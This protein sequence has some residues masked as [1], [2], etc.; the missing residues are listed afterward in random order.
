MARYAVRYLAAATAGSSPGGARQLR[1]TVVEA[2]DAQ[3]VAR[4]LAV[5]PADI[6]KLQPLDAAPAAA[7]VRSSRKVAFPLRL[8]SQELA[9]LLDAGI[10]LF[11][12]LVTLR[13]KE[14]AGPTVE[15]LTRVI[16][17]LEQGQ[18]FAQ[19]LRGCPEAFSSL[20]IA[21]IEASQR[22]GQI[23]QALRRH[24]EYLAWLAALR[25]KLV[26]AL[27]YPAILIAAGSLVMLFL[28]VF[29]VPR[30]AQIYDDL[31]GDLP[32]MSRVMLGFGTF[33]GQNP[34]IVAG[35]VAG[36]IAGVV[37]A[38]RSPRVR[39]MLAAQLWAMPYVGERMRLVELSALY[40]TLGLLLQAG[41]TAVPAMQASSELVS[42]SLRV[43]L[44]DATRRVRE[45]ARLSDSL[46]QAGL[47]TPVSLRMMRV[48]EHS[49]ELGNMLE[50]AATFY[51]EELA[52][53]TEW[54]GRVVSPALMLIMGVMIGGVVV[55]MYL[56]I[57]QVAEQIR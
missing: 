25:D 29:V 3:A 7:A 22:T 45:G 42:P 30:F 24:A 12:S 38:W 21:S 4:T 13:E 43:S 15:V 48:G 27:I 49:G 17:S 6:V 37:V 16:A 8:F 20:F 32:W 47:T 33:V 50:R 5:R 10:P 2:A 36:M 57:F 11:E 18:N 40:R 39:A 51:D 14:S 31:G 44:A 53:F 34:L 19:A 46:D 52:R 41:V 55:L 56:P 26:G 23:A 54:I 9:V 28:T 35:I 1:D